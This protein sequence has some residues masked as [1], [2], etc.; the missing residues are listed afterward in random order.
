MAIVVETGEGIAN[1]NSY[2]SVADATA[3][4]A[5]RGVTLDPD[6][7]EAQIILATD[8]LE[9]FGCSYLG[10]QTYN[11]Q[12]LAWP[13]T[14]VWIAGVEMADDVIPNS[15]KKA[16]QQLVI[17]QANGFDLM[18]STDGQIVKVE[19]VDVISTEYAVG[20]DWGESGGPVPAFPR[21]DALLKALLKGECCDDSGAALRLV[22][23]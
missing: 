22:R 12:E 21:V 8:Y 16:Q 7:V 9:T 11:P 14:G 13:R 6:T 4:A 10:K 18:P 1:A 5:A 23:I 15:L 2:V 3:Y 19:K 20:T 17:E